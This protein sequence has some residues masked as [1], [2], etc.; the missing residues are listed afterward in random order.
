MYL[1]FIL[2][3]TSLPSYLPVEEMQTSTV[4]YDCAKK[5][6]KNKQIEAEP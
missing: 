5:D 6:C 3:S 1:A 4:E 2:N